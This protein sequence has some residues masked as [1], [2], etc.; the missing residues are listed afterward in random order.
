MN[1]IENPRQILK[2]PG[3]KWNIAPK[4]TELIPPHHSYIEPF[5][6]SGALFFCKPPSNIET[7]NDLNSDVTNLFQCI[8]EDA[9]RLAR[10]LI[11]IPF[12]REVYE[13]QFDKNI[14]YT[15]NYERAASMLVRCW[16]SFGHRANNEKVG[17]KID[18]QGRE[19]MYALWNWYRLPE[20]IIEICE[21]L[22]TV[23][24]ENRPATELIKL[25]N[26]DCVFQYWDPPYMLGTRSGK[27]Y[28]HEMTDKEHEEL[29]TL[30]LQSKSMIMISGYESEL[31]NDM[32]HDWNKVS[33]KSCA[34]KGAPR[35]EI[36]WMNY[37]INT[38]IS[39]LEFLYQ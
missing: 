9:E 20:W 5:F 7:I 34:E 36:V 38:T 23:Q 32:L 35:S 3:S 14:A 31:Y 2:Y 29:L 39:L 28:I 37:E 17:W 26:N 16:Q 18:V 1:I 15:D 4:L 25:F 11:T 10:L 12:S 27:Q 33:F 22:R 13:K 21:R 24:I 8:Q 6:G 30:A 19:R